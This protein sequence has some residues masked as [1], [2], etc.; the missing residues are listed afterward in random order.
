[1]ATSTAAAMNPASAHTA[2]KMKTRIIAPTKI[3][4]MIAVKRTGR[5]PALAPGR[6]ADDAWDEDPHD[7]R[8][9]EERDPLHAATLT[10]RRTRRGPAEA[11]PPA[12]LVATAGAR[13]EGHEAGV[14]TPGSHSRCMRESEPEVFVRLD[15]D[16][17]AVVCELVPVR[18]GQLGGAVREEEP[19]R[20]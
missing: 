9:H 11:G 14:A 13:H 18:T 16:D 2:S 3:A 5:F 12:Q 17:E 15:L 1:M 19:L 10:G 20:P 4:P 8:H 6:E 7:Q